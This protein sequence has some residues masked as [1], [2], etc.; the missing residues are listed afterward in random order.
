[1]EMSESNEAPISEEEQEDFFLYIEENDITTIKELLKNNIKLWKY[2]NKDNDNCTVLHFSVYKKLYEMTELF[3]SYCKKKISDKLLKDFINV[4]NDKGVTAIHFAS[5]RGN[6]Q[7][8]KLL[9][10]NGADIYAKANRDLNVIHY[11]GQGNRPNSLMFFYLIFKK[12]NDY[13]LITE[14]DSGGSTPLHWAAYS[15]AEDVLLYL[16][17]LNI[18]D[19]ER[20]KKEFIDKTDLHKFTALHLSVIGKS[21]RI[22]MKLLQNGASSDIKNDKE[23]T[24]LD[25]AKNKKLKEIEEIIRNNQNV[26]ICNIKAPVKQIKKSYKNIICVAI[27]QSLTT[28][29][30]FFSIIP[31]AFNTEEKNN[32]ALYNT[33]FIIYLVLLL[34][35]ILI[36][37]ILI[38]RDP[39]IIQSKTLND[40]EILLNKNADLTKYCYRCYIERNKNVKHC[41]ICNKCYS[42][43]D[44]HCYWINQCVAKRNFKLFLFFLFETFAYLAYVLFIC[45][46]GLVHYF[47]D[48]QFSFNFYG[49]HLK[50]ENVIL[51]KLG[52]YKVFHLI[53]NIIMIIIVLSFLIPEF[54]LLILH[55]NVYCTNYRQKK[56]G[57]RVVEKKD[58]GKQIETTLIND[59]SSNSS[60]ALIN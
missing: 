7:I 5:F 9:T 19:N 34:L 10:D 17:N 21:I 6:V 44:H 18:F 36:Y 1:M 2:R 8:L 52:E 37:L 38:I 43:F 25:L 35:F 56:I 60:E 39:G 3:I 54:L 28:F 20:E 59:N 16:I 12:N 58:G 15:N 30:L 53:L 13:R 32:E 51:S 31:F 50:S 29:S 48:S 42:D 24:P 46:F 27:F 47:K 57:E 45:I 33:L 26:Q 55:I 4:K 40:L 14:Q 49:I 41:I 23:Q 22:V 11:A